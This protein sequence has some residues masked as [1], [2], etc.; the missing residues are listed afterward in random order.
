MFDFLNRRDVYSHRNILHVV[1]KKQHALEEKN[2]IVISHK[3]NSMTKKLKK[4]IHKIKS[5]R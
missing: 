3:K 2:T 5:K 4:M 1:K